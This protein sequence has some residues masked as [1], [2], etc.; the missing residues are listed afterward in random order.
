MNRKTSLLVGT[1]VAAAAFAMAGPALAQQ[2]R[3]TSPDRST[4]SG[5]V[6]AQDTS[7]DEAYPEDY[8]NISPTIIVSA[9]GVRDL[10]IL[11]GTSVLQGLD[12]QRNLT[13]QLGDT[14]E[15]LPGVS[16]SGF[17]PGASRPI[18]RGFSGERVRTLIDGLGSFDV[19]NTSDDHAVAIEP[20]L[21]ERIEVLRG[22]AVLLYGSQAI[23]GAVNVIDKRI[24]RAPLDK[25]F[26]LDAAGG[27]ETVNDQYNIGGSLDVALAPGLIAHVDGA[28]RDAGNL[29]VPGYVVSDRLRADLLADA[30][31][32][33]AEGELDEAEELREIAN[34]RGVLPN[35]YF[36]TYNF[37]GGLALFRG[38]SNFGISAGY[39][40]TN[41]GVPERPGAGHHHEG[42]EGGEEEGGEE[43][44]GGVSIG[45]EQFRADYRGELALGNG[46]F[47]TLV[48]RVGY[49]DYTHTE[50]EG[51][52]VGTVFDTEN[53]E[54][55][56]ELVQNSGGAL[57][58]S[59]G[60]QYLF[61]DFQA[62]GEEAFVAPNRTNQFAVFALQEYGTGPF[63]IEGAARYE[64][65]NVESIMLGVDRDFDAFSGALGV[66]YQIENGLR[67]G[68]NGS[69]VVRAPSGEELFANGPHV[70]T[71][72]FEVGDTTLALEKA[73]GVEAYLRG[74]VGPA[75][76]NLAAF[77]N[78]FDNYIYLQET[79][80][81]EDDLP[82]FAYLQ[83]DARYYGFE[84]EIAF[85]V[86]RFNESLSLNA[87]LRGEYVRAE[88]DDDINVPRIPPLG[89][90]GAL[91]LQGDRFDVRGEVEW[92]DDQ[93]KVAP[94]ETPT[95]GFTFVN[96]SVAFRPLQ[97]NDNVT[98]L[99]QVQNI[100]DVEGR[101]A[102]SF[103]KDFVPLGGRNFRI[104]LR[105]SF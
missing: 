6:P 54:A 8:H 78:W 81:E 53:I 99:A 18:L 52:E 105:S 9:R 4:Q 64:A 62:V 30:D 15:S 40:D 88:L 1:C 28:Y 56:A 41:Y 47:E 13:G 94:F 91:S 86:T 43:E 45:L 11:A 87:D 29:E 51:A 32:E 24:P 83:D 50:F 33:E 103:T 85:P 21:V 5:S 90:S 7:S 23:G 60:V 74:N 20:L 2:T 38:D 59:V 77:H 22:P 76:I 48:T 25:P 16:S 46:F 17:S 67:F 80:E 37:G 36:E 10:D 104:S 14:L 27:Y 55:R 26:H 97:G 65:T 100:F 75:T 31:A 68:V 71:Q 44:E 58:G 96:A 66:S 34:Q 92:Y 19:S 57:R 61:R 102:T 79:G 93:N 82:V 69:R 42:E 12:L 89:L 98:L 95:D 63:Q 70:A 101:R 84:G 73:W 3:S 72:Q 49:S 39:Y 35:S